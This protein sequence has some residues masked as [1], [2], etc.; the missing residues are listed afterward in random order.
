MDIQQIIV[1]DNV[2]MLMLPEI[3]FNHKEYLKTR[4]MD[5]FPEDFRCLSNLRNMRMQIYNMF[6]NT[7]DDSLKFSLQS[8][9]LQDR[10]IILQ[11]ILDRF[12]KVCY[13]CPSSLEYHRIDD[14]SAA[15]YT[16]FKVYLN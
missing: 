1:L 14:V 16:E 13:L 7:K 3:K 5:E 15:S 12:D 10:K 4:K 9:N 6:R 2:M 11:E 8:L